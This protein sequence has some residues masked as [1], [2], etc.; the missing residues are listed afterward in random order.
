MNYI[1]SYET[2]CCFSQYSPV[3]T[4]NKHG[5]HNF[6]NLL[7]MTSHETPLLPEVK[8]W[9]AY[10]SANYYHLVLILDVHILVGLSM[11]F[12]S[13]YYPSSPT[14]YLLQF[15]YHA[16]KLHPTLRIDVTSKCVSAWAALFDHALFSCVCPPHVFSL[17]IFSCDLITG[18][19][20]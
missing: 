9:S 11:V 3:Q 14:P 7:D 16:C 19:T 4:V 18:H 20:L 8:K 2:F 1:K 17:C 13:I 15:F 10:H 5:D 12:S 6:K